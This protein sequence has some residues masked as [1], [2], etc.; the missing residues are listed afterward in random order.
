MATNSTTF[1]PSSHA[2]K[3]G[4]TQ[5]SGCGSFEKQEARAMKRSCLLLSCLSLLAM[6]ACT[7]STGS[8]PQRNVAGIS[9]G[10]I[11][12]GMSQQAVRSAWGKP[13]EILVLS[14]GKEQWIYKRPADRY[15]NF[16]ANLIAR[17]TTASF[18][19]EFVRGSS[20]RHE[21]INVLDVDRTVV[22]TNGKVEAWTQLRD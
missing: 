16:P 9:G 1:Q 6:A 18:D 15:L 17:G 21:R 22:F 4:K 8:R 5:N 13:N 14:S 19:D 7:P 20:I 12:K 11:T 2:H 3:L 10:V